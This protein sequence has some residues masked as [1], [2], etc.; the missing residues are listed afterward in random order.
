MRVI[1]AIAVLFASS[2]AGAPD[3]S[4]WVEVQGGAW[5]PQ[6]T[7]LPDLETVLRPAVADA[8]KNRGRAPKWTEYTFQYQGRTSLL[9]RRYIYVNAFCGTSEVQITKSWVTVMDGGACYFSAMYDPDT[10]RV[11]DLVINGVA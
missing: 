4:R 9:G 6:S 3:H 11:Y 8:S 5:H 1:V 10:N 7:V 2:V